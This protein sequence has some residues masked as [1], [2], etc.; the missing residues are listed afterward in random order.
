MNELK[1]VERKIL[2]LWEDIAE[3]RGFDRVLGRVLC[4]LLIERRP[5]S[6]QEL[7]EK[8]GYSIPTISKILKVLISMGTG[9][10]IKKPGTRTTQYYVE[11]QP[12]ELLS[13]ALIK[14]IN[15]TKIME[16]RTLELRQEV[17]NSKSEDPERAE[18]LIIMLTTFITAI[19][20]VIE[21]MEKA[22]KEMQEL[23]W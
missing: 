10:K 1:S 6:Q 21:T 19:P 22:I 9:R 16:K 15:T 14:W 8:T 11:I 7:A 3:A 2:A 5:L 23:E 18:K 13:G 4:T 17:E 12:W 20:K